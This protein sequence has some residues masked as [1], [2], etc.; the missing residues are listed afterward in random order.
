VILVVFGKIV[1]D[2]LLARNKFAF[3]VIKFKNVYIKII[4]SIAT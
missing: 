1:I 2:F 3:D 4:Y